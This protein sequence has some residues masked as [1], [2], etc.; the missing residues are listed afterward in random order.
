MVHL[1]NSGAVLYFPGAHQDMIRPGIALYGCY[2]DGQQGRGDCSELQ[3]SPVMRFSSRVIQVKDVP[4]GTGLG[5]GH[6][7]ITKRPTRIA[8]IPVG[9][10]DGYL[11]CL[12]NKAQGLIQGKRVSVVGRISM[13][14]T[15]FDVTDIDNVCPGDEVVL[16]GRQGM[17]EITADEIACWMQTINYEVCCLFGNLNQRLYVPG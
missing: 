13:N 11:R 6:S 9:Y 5:Y 4:A 15:M 1:A 10:E 14:I 17:S 16:L 8:L 3:L 7:F 2:P 12:S